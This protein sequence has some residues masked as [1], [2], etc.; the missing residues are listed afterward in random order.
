MFLSA[1]RYEREFQFRV[2]PGSITLLFTIFV[3]PD[4]NLQWQKS[5]SWLSES[6]YFTFITLATLGYGDILPL[7]P[8]ARSLAIFIT[9]SE[10]VFIR[11]GE[12][13]GCAFP[14]FALNPYPAAMPFHQF[15]AKR[16]P[17]PCSFFVECTSG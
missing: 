8:Y 17:E 2:D 14:E 10:L 15:S 1:V 5:L 7:K 16:Q 11:H 12:I 13:S 6:I 9:V 3:L 4:I